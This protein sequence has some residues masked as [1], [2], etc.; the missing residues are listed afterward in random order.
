MDST[1]WACTNG[2]AADEMF[3]THL[4]IMAAKCLERYRVKLLLVI[5][6]QMEV[7]QKMSTC[8]ALSGASAIDYRYTFTSV[9]LKDS[10]VLVCQ[11]GTLLA[12]YC[13]V[14]LKY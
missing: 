13:I 14:D 9:G 6:V 1:E 5:L 7:F 2:R 4:Q 11:G 12:R 3:Y 8:I 10:E